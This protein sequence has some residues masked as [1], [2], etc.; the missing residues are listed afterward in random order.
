MRWLVV[1]AILAAARPAA[2]GIVNVQSFLASEAPEGVSGSV[3]GSADWRTGN[4]E[5]L[6]LAANPIVRYRSGDHLGLV[7]VSGQLGDSAG[8]RI[9]AKTFEHVR[10]RYTFTERLLGEV[11]AQHEYDQFRDL[12][13]R[14]L[15]GVGPKLDLVERDGVELGVGVAY[16]LEF[17]RVRSTNAEGTQ[18]RA[19]SYVLGR[20]KVNDKVDFVET[21][22]V[23]PLLTDPGDLRLL[24]DSAL[25]VK[26]TDKVSLTSS[27]NLAYDSEPP[28]DGVDSLDTTLKTSITVSF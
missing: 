13:L 22:Y 3:T 7:I 11:F 26:L 20:V 17:E 1:F 24:N 6:M 4:T 19:S 15:I 14:A 21:F 9:I 25:V 12:E 16:M 5:L 28:T 10:Y 18:H 2:A 23:Q 27:F 8:E